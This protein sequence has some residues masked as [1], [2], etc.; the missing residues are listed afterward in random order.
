MRPVQPKSDLTASFAVGPAGPRSDGGGLYLGPWQEYALWRA[1]SLRQREAA[2]S[3]AS[4]FVLA[5]DERR[6]PGQQTTA[7]SAAGRRSSGS[8]FS[9]SL[10]SMSP[11]TPVG[12]AISA[13]SGLESVGDVSSMRS[14]DSGGPGG[15]GRLRR[16]GAQAARPLPPR[17]AAAPKHKPQSNPVIDVQSRIERLRS[18]YGMSQQLPS[19]AAKEAI[20]GERGDGGATPPRHALSAPRTADHDALP[21]GVASPGFHVTAAVESGAAAAGAAAEAREA[22]L[23]SLLHAQAARQAALEA[24]L[25][26]QQVVSSQM[27]AALARL[28]G[29]EAAPAAA[30]PASRSAVA[31]VI[32]TVAASA[33][34]TDAIAAPAPV[35]AAAV[36]VPAAAPELACDS[37][38]WLPVRAV[39]SVAHPTARLGASG[40]AP[41]STSRVPAAGVA[42]EPSQAFPP[43]PT[44]VP[45][46]FGPPVAKV[47]AAPVP[48]GVDHL[49]RFIGGR[50]RKPEPAVHAAA[51]LPQGHGSSSAGVGEP[52]Q[53]AGAAA[54]VL[55]QPAPSSPERRGSVPDAAAEDLL[56]WSEAL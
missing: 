30:R 34:C 6:T 23:V 52:L 43:L 9:R 50:P 14:I 28:M 5:P 31:P 1:H 54:S 47:D 46:L 44:A 53:G 29:T 24:Q 3:S 16:A 40:A 4:S 48:G 18:L 27:N 21:V 39:Q 15:G 37:D 32:V 51:P 35:A 10:M 25:Q 42:S 55:E 19:A 11:G 2:G 38:S 20:R 22:Q 13:R 41:V 45:A 49:L 17:T 33:P 12:P 26:R 36:F 7:L 56:R 8:S